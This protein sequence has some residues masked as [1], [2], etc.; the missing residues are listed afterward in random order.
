MIDKNGLFFLENGIAAPLCKVW[1]V[2]LLIG[3]SSLVFGQKTMNLNSVEF[4]KETL[5]SNLSK[6]AAFYKK[7]IVSQDICYDAY[8]KVSTDF[9]SI[10]FRCNKDIGSDDIVRVINHLNSINKE[11]R[12]AQD[13]FTEDVSE[14][15][16]ILLE[17]LRKQKFPRNMWNPTTT[18]E[19]SNKWYSKLFC[20]ALCTL[21]IY[22]LLAR[23]IQSYQKITI[24]NII[25][26]LREDFRKFG[27]NYLIP[28]IYFLFAVYQFIKKL[29]AELFIPVGVEEPLNNRQNNNGKV[30]THAR[31]DKKE[32][33]RLANIERDKKET[34]RL[35]NL[36]R[37]KKE[38]E[39]LANIERDKKETE[40]LA[41]IERDRKEAE[42]LAN[43]ERDK[44][45]AERLA[46]IKRD[47][48]E[49]ERLANLERDRKE[50]ERLAN[51]ER[52]KKE[53][54][55]LAKLKPFFMPVPSG[56]RLFFD[57]N[58]FA[59]YSVGRT[60]Y[61]FFPKNEHEA[62]FEFYEEAS[63]FAIDKPQTHI[64][65]ACEPLN[66]RDNSAKGIKTKRRGIVFLEADG[67]WRVEEKAKIEYIY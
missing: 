22:L 18:E 3:W 13:C 59:N 25:R 14:Q 23:T 4:R 20:F 2:S 27:K 28:I 5:G 53:A 39:R 51:L 49:A 26:Q 42:R 11:Y 24:P 9:D 12:D 33:E 8:L 19:S 48:K 30:E 36:E 52:D 50:A 64:E 58:R 7:K 1:L 54:E 61:K 31:R 40:R 65:P 60:T 34:E 66:A 21:L 35:A 44:K 32:A 6:L 55:R 38:A 63:S 43:I 16:K 29:I 41:N 62:E 46:N 67:T 47:R 37:D 10:I 45:E 17:E 56:E 57:G 15:K